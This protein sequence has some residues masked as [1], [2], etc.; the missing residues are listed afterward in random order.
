MESSLKL[1][2]LLAILLVIFLGSS[3]CAK[4]DNCNGSGLCGSR[5]NQADC[6]R[7]ISR[8]TDGTIYNGFTSRVSGHCTAIF[9]CDGN[10]P[11]VSGAVL[12]QQFLHV[13]DNQ[14]C[15]LC[16]SH[17]FDGGNCEATLNYCANCRD[18]GNPNAVEN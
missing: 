17:A 2:S 10:Y 14:P 8:Y 1:F 15:R 4:N 9:R 7:A 12:K 18:S 13:Y 16:G 5:V 11:S 3:S 6:R